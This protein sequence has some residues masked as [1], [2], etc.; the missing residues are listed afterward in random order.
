LAKRDGDVDGA[1]DYWNKVLAVDGAFVAARARLAEVDLGTARRGQAIVKLNAIVEKERFQP[2]ARNALAQVAIEAKDYPQALIHS[3]N[4]LLGDPANVNAYL[5]MA[6]SYFRQRLYDQALLI[7]K[8]AMERTPKAASLHNLRGL[9]Y[10]QK[11]NSRSASESFLRAAKYDPA[12]LD[13]LLNLGSLELSYGDFQSAFT[14]FGMVLKKRPKDPRL[15]LSHGVALRGLGRFAEARKGYERALELKPDLHEAHYN[16][17]VLHYQFT[18]DYAE[19]D[20]SCKAYFKTIKRGHTK[21]REMRR[22]LKSIK[23]TLNAQAAEEAAKKAAAACKPTCKGRQCGDDGCG[24]VCGT[25]P[26]GQACGDEGA[27]K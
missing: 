12:Q 27:C 8:S 19:A 6:V 25:C 13:A 3:R 20:K 26:E 10:L 2:E 9:I 16:L 18:S 23:D 7:I 14:H 17:C 11:D 1:R 4:V 5:N 24:G 22:R 15:L 21:F